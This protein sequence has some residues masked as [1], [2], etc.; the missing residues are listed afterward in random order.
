MPRA[1]HTVHGNVE[2]FVDFQVRPDMHGRCTIQQSMTKHL[3]EDKNNDGEERNNEGED[4]ARGVVHLLERSPVQNAVLIGLGEG[5]PAHMKRVTFPR[6]P[7][8][9]MRRL[10]EGRYALERGRNHI[11]EGSMHDLERRMSR[12]HTL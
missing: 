11:M 1:G 3:L 8:N 6:S 2:F 12:R 9:T 4:G 5:V 10:K 7:A